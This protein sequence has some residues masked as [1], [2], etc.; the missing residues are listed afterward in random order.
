VLEMN[1]DDVPMTVG[2]VKATV[3]KEAAVEESQDIEVMRAS[4]NRKSPLEAVLG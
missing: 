3:E 2:V 1:A 4:L